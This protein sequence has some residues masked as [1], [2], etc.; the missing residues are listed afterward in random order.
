[1]TGQTQRIEYVD[2]AK[3]F[4]ILLVVIYH[5]GVFVPDTKFPG[6]VVCQH[7]RMPLY[8]FLSG[9]FFKPYEG[10]CR[11]SGNSFL[12][13]KVNKLL[14]P[15]LFFYLTTSV[16]LP[17]VLHELLGVSG[18]S[19]FRFDSNLSG[20]AR[21]YQPLLDEDYFNDSSWFLLC[22]FFVNAIFYAVYWLANQVA[23]G[24]KAVAL[25]GI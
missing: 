13:R 8:F 10:F 19:L 25:I 2:L 5:I 7:F 24:G 22:L 17:Y 23:Q 9:L 11:L 18:N 6:T 20:W 12:R 14:V 1:M 3:G 15:F 21:L 16:A 4:C